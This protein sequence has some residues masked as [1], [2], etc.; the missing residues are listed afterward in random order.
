MYFTLMARLGLPQPHSES[1][2][3]RVAA[4]TEGACLRPSG[5]SSLCPDS[6]VSRDGGREIT[7]WRLALLSS[8]SSDL[9]HDLRA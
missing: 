8:V 6:Q 7:L 2:W 3:S 1:Q 4:T 9:Q 5:E